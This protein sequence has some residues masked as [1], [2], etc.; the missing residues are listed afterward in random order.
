MQIIMEEHDAKAEQLG[1]NAQM[2]VGGLSNEAR[3]LV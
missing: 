2:V 1:T 3:Q